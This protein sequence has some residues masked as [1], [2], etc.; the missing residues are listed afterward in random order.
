LGLGWLAAVLFALLFALAGGVLGAWAIRSRARS[1]L[2]VALILAF[3]LTL[4]ALSFA[5]L[6][7]AGQI[8]VNTRNRLKNF[9]QLCQALEEQYPYFDLKNINWVETCRRYQPLVEATQTDP[10]YHALVAE[11]LAGLGDAH[12]G[13]I[14][15]R[16][17][18]R[19]YFGRARLL[20]DGVVLTELGETAR[21]AGLERG[22]EILAVNGLPAAEALSHL[23][24]SLRSGSTAWQSNAW[25]AD[26]L[27][28]AVNESIV[29]S[30][31]NPGEEIKTVTLG[32]VDHPALPPEP[33]YTPIITGEMLS[34]GW[35]LIR[36]PTFSRNTGHDL[37]A[38][39]DQALEE[40][41]SASGLIL[42]LRGNGGGDSRLAEQIAGRFFNKRFCYGSDHF[43]Q[44]LPQR[45]W[46]K[47]FTYCVQPRGETITLPLTLLIDARNMSSA[48]QFIT[49]FGESG[50]A[51]TLG[52]RTGGA[53]GNPLTFPL[54]G[55]GRMRFST[56]AFYTRS[57][58]LV[59]GSGILPD[60]PVPYLVS[61]FQQNR[62]PVLLAAQN[63]N[64]PR[65][66]K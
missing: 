45:A 51:T 24:L 10:E 36:L 12:T 34:S 9:E 18:Q 63:Q 65:P 19:H 40:V 7:S 26:H 60:V 43:R 61:D 62:D 14:Q 46:S 1:R 20:S 22:A 8:L 31:R 49:I 64:G 50:R 16:S 56:G 25:G 33:T 59:E 13:L 4:G 6:H 17:S 41:R 66:S 54:P 58:L 2:W 30:Y 11:M 3:I 52:E 39:F 55:E 23:P 29:V 35:G 47:R 21:Q 53:S 27:F 44:R 28:S 5:Q 38:E 42:D 32:W 57:G 37:L 48:E 15:P